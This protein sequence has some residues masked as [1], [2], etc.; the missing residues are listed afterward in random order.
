MTVPLSITLPIDSSPSEKWTPSRAVGTGLKVLS[1]LLASIP[2]LNGVNFLGSKVSVWG[3]PPAIHSRITV[4][5]V[6]GI[7]GELQEA[8][9]L[10]TGAPAASAAMVAALVLFRN[11]LLLR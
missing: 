4:S 6:E 11:C 5:A 3:M 1:T 7:F 8:R 10:V 9:K 2:F